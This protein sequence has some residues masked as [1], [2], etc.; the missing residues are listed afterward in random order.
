[1]L[2]AGLV[3]CMGYAVYSMFVPD[4]HGNGIGQMSNEQMEYMAEVRMRNMDGL[5]KV[6]QRNLDERRGMGRGDVVYD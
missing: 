2:A 6:G 3:V 4:G 5:M 1:M